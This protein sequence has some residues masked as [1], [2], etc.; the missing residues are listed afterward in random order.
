MARM[1][2]GD[3]G[4]GGT[5]SESNAQHI[6]AAPGETV[7]LP[8]ID[9]ITHADMLRDGQDLILQAP[10]GSQVVI[11]DYFAMEPAPMLSAPNGAVLTPELVRSFVQSAHPQYAAADQAADE[12]PVG[13]VQ[14]VSGAAT[15]TRTDGTVE[16]LAVGMPIF[17]GDVIETDADGAINIVFIDETSFAVSADAKLAIDEYVFDPASSSGTTNFSVLRGMFVFSSGLIGREDPDDVTIETPVGSIGIRGTT[18]A[19]NATTGEVTVV[20]GAIVLRS[21]TGQEVTLATQ[22][23]TARFSAQGVSVT[24]TMEPAQLAQKFSGIGGVTPSFFSAIGAEPPASNGAEP[25]Q[26]NAPGNSGGAAPADGPQTTGQATQPAAEPSPPP[27]ADLSMNMA[28]DNS[29]GN[30]N[31]FSGSSG[32]DSAAGAAGTGSSIAPPPAPAANAGVPSVSSSASP[33]AAAAVA[34]TPPPVSESIAPPPTV[35][36]LPTPVVNDFAPVFATG[37][38]T[39]IMPEDASRLTP[40]SG[41][42]ATDADGNALTYSI[43]GGTGMGVFAMD[44]AGRIIVD[45]PLNFETHSSYT[46][47]L[48]VSDGV[49]TVDSVVYTINISDI[50]EAAVFIS[51]TTASVLESAPANTLVYD[52]DVA[53]PE[54]ATFSYSI[55]SGN[56]S[57]L[58]LI[59]SVTGEVRLDVQADADVQDTYTIVIRADDGALTVD[60]TVTITI[61]D[62]DDE[63]V[64]MGNN[65]GANVA[66]GGTL[67]LTAAMLS[68]TDVDT[69][70]A[71]L[72]YSVSAVTGGQLERVGVP[73]TAITSFTQADIDSGQIAFV[74]DGIGTGAAQAY[75]SFTATDGINTPLGTQTFT[76]NIHPAG[77][78]EGDSDGNVLAGDAGNNTIYGYE[79]NDTLI[80]GGGNNIL[81]GGSGIDIVDYSNAT[82]SISVDLD[83]GTAAANGYGGTDTLVNIETVYGSSFA[84]II[85]GSMS[86]PE[87]LSG[88]DGNDMIYAFISDTVYGGGGDDSVFLTDS[89]NG[90]VIYGGTGNDTLRLQGTFYDFTNLTID[91]MEI[92]D[93]LGANAS[94]KMKLGVE[95][96][97]TLESGKLTINLDGGDNLSLDLSNF[98]GAA[99]FQLVAGNMVTGN[100]FTLRNIGS[101]QEIVVNY[102]AGTFIDVYGVSAPGTADLNLNLMGA[103]SGYWVHDDIGEGFGFALAALGDEDGDGYADIGIVKEINGTSAAR[104]F[105]L[106]GDGATPGSITL[107]AAITANRMDST[108]YGMPPGSNTSALTVASIGDFDGDGVNDLVIGA[109]HAMDS[110]SGVTEAGAV[111]IISGASGLPIIAIGGSMTGAHMGRS[112]AGVGDVNGDGFDDILVGAPD[113][114]GDAGAAYLLF[115]GNTDD[116]YVN[117]VLTPDQGIKISGITGNHLGMDVAGIGDF[118]G[119]GLDDFMLSLP[120]LAGAGVA[121]I[122]FG[123]QDMSA[124]NLSNSSTFKIVNINVEAGAERD[125]PMI[126]LGDINGDG[127]SD[128]ALAATGSSEIHIFHGGAGRVGGSYDANTQDSTTISVG[129]GYTIVGGGG[130]GDFNGDGM[131]DFAVAVQQD[132]TRMVDIYVVYDSAT[133]PGTINLGYLNTAANSYHMTYTIPVGTSEADFSVS[134]IGAG[135]VNGDGYADLALGFDG[136]D[137]LSGTSPNAADGSVAIVYGQDS[138]AGTLRTGASA[139]SSGAGE[140]L[141][142]TDGNDTITQ[143][144]AG[145]TDLVMRGGRGDDIFVLENTSF[146]D[147]DGGMGHDVLSFMSA[148]TLSFAALQSEDIKGIEQLR[149]NGTGQTLVL[150]LQNIF[151]LLQHSDEG[152]LR[153][154]STGGG[155]VLDIDGPAAQTGTMANVAAALGADTFSDTAGYWT[156]DIGG[157]ELL[158]DNTMTVNII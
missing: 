134:I 125:I 98:T 94:I 80:G 87:T 136:V 116:L 18:I 121:H 24:G 89:H 128:I 127:Y 100:T 111:Q 93:A 36:P 90:A 113:A 44:A 9:F 42:M 74:D 157:K 145:H 102:D 85:K 61:G 32:F 39:F 88:G 84:D 4:A 20:E 83:V 55:V 107:P 151:S 97:N 45:G 112:V 75:F 103:G 40:V 48:R 144:A 17:Q 28:G 126:A 92:I 38:T 130:A 114:S 139:S 153:I 135:D 146:A 142:G 5:G 158:I 155:G 16:K 120:G 73:G 66:I 29:F 56:S 99:G 143:G 51:G 52:A 91:S 67:V 108:P 86:A 147:I 122:V 105:T 156:F 123:Q 8:S 30:S 59:D 152:S 19:G 133:M 149:I 115:G 43:V 22:F 117:A 81:D 21:P 76:M 33:P 132:G 27:G 118:N 69:A 140:R 96:M 34:T 124:I 41:I 23:E 49:H 13:A 109:P 2:A 78:I 3:L 25:A 150:T 50:N 70:A 110:D 46:L 64:A 63:S 95:Y 137:N 77:L 11:S 148:G 14:E 12:S 129:A 53:D 68:V 7:T 37:T 1:T 26:N 65:T 141:V 10:D 15:V 104:L 60:Q 154:E 138:G 54:S 72:V 6:A 82:A 131:D 31:S 79:G 106:Y 71:N 101:G 62:V 35:T 57:G 58:F 47:E 119:D